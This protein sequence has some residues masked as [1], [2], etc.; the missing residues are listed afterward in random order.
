MNVEQSKQLSLPD[1]LARL[2]HQPVKEAKAGRE[3]WFRSPFREEAEPSFHASIGRA[4]FWIWKDFGDEGGTVIDFVMRYQGYTQIKDALSFLNA[5]YQPSLFSSMPS[6]H[7]PKAI[8]KP[9]A[10]SLF[11]FHQQ[12]DRE[13]VENFSENRQLEFLG[14]GPIQS[15]A[16]LNYLIRERHIPVE[17]VQRYLQEVRYRNTANGKEYFAFGMANQSN[18]FE[19]RVASSRYSFKSALKARDIT[20]IPGS[21]PNSQDVSVFEGMTDFLSLLAMQERQSLPGHA[22]IMHS[23]SS[24]RRAA[25]AIQSAG[26][27]H[28]KTYLDNNRPGQ[29][30]TEKFKAEFGSRVFSQS[31]TFAPYTD[32][33]DALKAYQAQKNA[34]GFKK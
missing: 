10:P 19:I 11:S 9:E 31:E 18:G 20:I 8:P 22:I 14:A 21:D 2:G 16:I 27:T 25:D 5:M 33:N 15:Q 30:G 4:G 12:K 32:L 3:L 24:Y 1:I 28:V 26:Y 13:A 17:L 34:V 23:L 6:R 29:E 7:K